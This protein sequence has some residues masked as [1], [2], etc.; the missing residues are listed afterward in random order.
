[1]VK[2]EVPIVGSG[3]LWIRVDVFTVGR[4][5][6]GHGGRHPSEMRDPGVRGGSPPWRRK[7]TP[8]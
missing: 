5:T 2:R 3:R 4:E 7:G 1:M 8:A 6:P